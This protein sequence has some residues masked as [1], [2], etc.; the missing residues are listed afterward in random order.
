[1]LY[2]QESV[3]DI[4]NDYAV[5]N[6][7]AQ[8]AKQRRLSKPA[9]VK[10]PV[11]KTD[12]VRLKLTLQEQRL[13]CFELERELC[14]MRSELQKS[15]VNVDHELSNDFA[16]LL[17]S[18]NNEITPFMS[19]FWQ[20]QQKLFSSSA[21]GVRYHPM[22]IRFCLSLAAKSPSC[23][24][25]LRNSGVLTLPSQRRLKPQGGFND[26]VIEELKTISNS[27]FDVQ[28]YVVLLFDEMKIQANLVLDKV[29]GELIG[30]TD[31]GDLDLNFAV[32]EKADEIA[33]HALVFLVRGMCTELKFAL[34]HFSTSE[35]NYVTTDPFA[36]ASPP[37]L[38]KMLTIL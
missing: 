5:H 2:S 29:T 19:L 12:P 23:Y 28:R 13:R 26:K 22:I 17:S 38:P 30:F 18:A 35:V 1:M 34:A 15:S 14:E 10:A 31:L 4:C 25:E 7:A 33:S 21:T 37:H 20:Q 24:E 27:Y 9:H 8:K 32:L 16:K 11:S 36:P 6:G 3:C